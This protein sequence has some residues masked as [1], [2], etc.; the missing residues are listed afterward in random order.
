MSLALGDMGSQN[1]SGCR[2]PI[3]ADR[4]IVG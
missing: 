4:F 1:A 3:L 2:V